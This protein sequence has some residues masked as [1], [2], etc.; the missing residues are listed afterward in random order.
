M[1]CSRY[2]SDFNLVPVSAANFSTVFDD[3]PY[4]FENN[5]PWP[6]NANGVYHGLSTMSYA[7]ANSTNTIPLKILDEL[8]LS[9]S[10]YFLRDYLH[11]DEP[12][13]VFILIT[14]F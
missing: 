13:N 9:H 6:K 8:G 2:D 1:T 7:M 11:L 3:V 14:N 12:N 10:F 5:K 4:S